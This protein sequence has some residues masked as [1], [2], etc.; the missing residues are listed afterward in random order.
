MNGESLE[1]SMVV[2]LSKGAELMILDG[3]VDIQMD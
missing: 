2:E 3:V 1:A